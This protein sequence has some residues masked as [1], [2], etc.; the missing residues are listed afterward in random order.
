MHSVAKSPKLPRAPGSRRPTLT[1]KA[2]KYFQRAE[3]G[4]QIARKHADTWR[5]AQEARDDSC[6]GQPRHTDNTQHGSN[7]GGLQK[8][9]VL[10]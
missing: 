8:K 10:I 1:L 3:P 7:S 2:V 6:A 4:T 5:T 9:R